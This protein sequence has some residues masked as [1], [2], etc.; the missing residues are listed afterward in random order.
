M[1]AYILE[2]LQLILRWLHLI[3]GVAWIG[4]SFSCVWLDNHLE[5]PPHWKKDKGIKGDLWAIHGGGI[6]E[7]AKYDLAPEK[8]PE[9]L[10]WF[11]WEA[12]S[13]W[14]TGMVL[15]ILVFYVGADAYLIDR[16]IAELSQSQAIGTGLGFILGG[17]V[18][19][20]LLCATPLA[21]NGYVLGL[22]LIGLA[23][24]TAYSLTHLFSGRGAYIHMGAIIGTIMAGN[25]FRVIMPSQRAL[26]AAIE[27]GGTPDPSWGLKAKV[28][29]THNNYF[30]LPLL[31]IMISN[32]YPMTYA[33]E[34]NWLILLAIIAITAFAR[35]YFNLRHRG[36]NKPIILV[37]SLLATAALAWAVMPKPAPISDSADTRSQVNALAAQKIL[38]Q[39][40][41]NCHSS[42]PTDEVFT[43]APMG[44]MLDTIEQMQQ[45]APLIKAHTVDSMDMPLLNPTRITPAKRAT[46]GEWIDAGAPAN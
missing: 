12:Y 38:T 5:D 32:H 34:H 1:E 37:V 33:H 26:I 28:R 11:K 14:L 16:R 3:T 9:T 35:H 42:R 31:F 23:V 44:V 4:A 45:W 21:R 40:C 20:E 46:L 13:T 6:Y 27:A 17:W 36:I 2:W 43:T 18:L 19:Y 15:M 30:T 24:M 8:K 41:T 39:H 22:V 7:V 25:V 10:H 29:S